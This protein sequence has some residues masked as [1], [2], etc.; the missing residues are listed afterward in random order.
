[1]DLSLPFRGT[2]AATQT[3]SCF[4]LLFIP[5]LILHLLHLKPIS[6][7]P[8][9]SVITFLKGVP[10]EQNNVYEKIFVCYCFRF[11]AAVSSAQNVGI[12]TT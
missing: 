1:M 12:G 6:L 7:R 5:I 8:L 2:G 9:S 4:H 10:L 3:G 11:A